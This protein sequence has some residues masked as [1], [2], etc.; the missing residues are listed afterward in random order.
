MM[1]CIK[2]ERH[3][4]AHTRP[5]EIVDFRLVRLAHE[6]NCLPFVVATFFFHAFLTTRD[7]RQND[8]KEDVLLPISKNG[9]VQQIDAKLPFFS[10]C[11]FFFFSRYCFCSFFRCLTRCRLPRSSILPAIQ[12]QEACKSTDS[13]VFANGGRVSRQSSLT[14][15]HAL[16]LFGGGK[17]LRL[18]W[19]SG[20]H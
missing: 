7:V 17:A 8:K 9:F 4:S 13:R 6:S 2:K 12:L 16:L 3:A 19:A 18:N 10:T 11:L 5:K 20:Q 14:G 15:W 1:D